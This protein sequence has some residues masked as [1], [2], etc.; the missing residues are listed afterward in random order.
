VGEKLETAAVYH[1][2]QVTRS[3]DSLEVLGGGAIATLGAL[4][5]CQVSVDFLSNLAGSYPSLKHL[6]LISTHRSNLL[7]SQLL[8]FKVLKILSLDGFL[9]RSMQREELDASVLRVEV[10]HLLFYWF[11]ESNPRD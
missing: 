9:L 10:R 8:K 11:D 5:T 4:S 1:F 7:S 6:P 3:L 2:F